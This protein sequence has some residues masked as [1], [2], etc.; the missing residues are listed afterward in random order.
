MAQRVHI[1]RTPKVSV[2]VPKNNH[3][4]YLQQRLGFYS[5]PGVSGDQVYRPVRLIPRDDLQEAVGKGGKF[6]S[7]DGLD[8]LSVVCDYLGIR[9]ID[10]FVKA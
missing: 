4:A 8:D 7:L 3:A 6:G 2:V 10:C 5:Q 1:A 9:S